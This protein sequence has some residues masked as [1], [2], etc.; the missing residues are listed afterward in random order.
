MA[1][2]APQNT[3]QPGMR[4]K[5]S[6]YHCYSRLS[7]YISLALTQ[8]DKLIRL[9]FFRW[10]FMGELQVGFLSGKFNGDSMQAFDVFKLTAD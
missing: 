8:K 6:I 3:N 4:I 5:V 9:R 7:P 10:L 2:P 1:A